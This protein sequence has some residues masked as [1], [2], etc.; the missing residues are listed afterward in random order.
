M[1]VTR[2][3]FQMVRWSEWAGQNEIAV[4]MSLTSTRILRRKILLSC[5]QGTVMLCNPYQAADENFIKSHTTAFSKRNA[6]NWLRLVVTADMATCPRKTVW[7]SSRSHPR[8][9]RSRIRLFA[10]VWFI[11]IKEIAPKQRRTTSTTLILAEGDCVSSGIEHLERASSPALQPMKC[12]SLSLFSTT[13]LCLPWYP[14]MCSSRPWT[15]N[16]ELMKL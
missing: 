6:H 13:P 2:R 9:R 15:Q 8:I 14:S 5:S 1:T 4:F 7:L 11:T 12:L 3:S 10:T 16:P